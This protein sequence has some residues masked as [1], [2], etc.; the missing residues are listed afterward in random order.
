MI[1]T[2]LLV[3]WANGWHD[4]TDDVAVGVHGRKEAMLSLGGAQSIAQAE[5]IAKSQ[6]E[7]FADPRT[8]IGCDI[9]PNGDHD[10]PYVDFVAGDFII[11]PDVPGRG[12]TRNQVQAITVTMDDDG[13]VTCAL[14]VRDILL[15]DRE[16]FDEAISK[17]TN[18]TLGGESKVAQPANLGY[19]INITNNYYDDG[20][21]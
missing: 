21:A 13:H 20:G 16:R 6:L 14:D 19:F 2:A 9:A 10:E 5:Q 4:V 18:G 15:D 3:R 7:I 17:M 11:C 1:V 8:E 12:A